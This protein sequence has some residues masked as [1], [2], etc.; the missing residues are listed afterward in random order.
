MQ[1]E[2]FRRKSENRKLDYELDWSRTREVIA[3]LVN[4]NRDKDKHPEAITG[5]D[6]RTLSFDKV[7]EK[8][9]LSIEEAEKQNAEDFKKIKNRLGSKFKKEDGK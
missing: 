6:I 9:P 8:T 7:E 1:I 5:Q 4:I 2:K 3:T